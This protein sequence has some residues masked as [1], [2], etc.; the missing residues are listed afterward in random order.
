MTTTVSPYQD[1]L[2]A[3]ENLRARTSR[4]YRAALHVHSPDSYDWNRTGDRTLNDRG[5]LLAQGGENGFIEALKEH[6]DLAVITDHMRCSYASRVSNASRNHSSFLVL[7]GMEVSFQPEAAISCTRL[8][9]LV[10]LPEGST[11][12]RFSRLF[13]TLTNIPDDAS[14]T[15]NEVVRNMRLADF[16][17]RV[18]AED[19]LCIAAHVNSQQGVRHH[20]RQTGEEIIRLL[21][22][23]PNTQAEQER[24]LSNELKEYLLEA[25]FDAL[26]V[27]KAAEKRHYRW[28][29]TVR[30]RQVV[31]PVTMQLDAHCIEDLDRPERVTW[32]KMTTL[33][34]RA[35]S[36]A[37]KF[38]ETRIRFSSELPTPPSP[39]L[40]GVEILGDD[41]SLFE[42]ERIAF[43]ENLNCLIGPRGS[44]KSTIVEAL[45]YVFGYNRTL[46]E[47]DTVNKLSDRIRDMQK[48][49]LTGCLIRV[50][51]Q[52]ES[53]EK[54]IL[55]ATFDPQEDYATRVFTPE[56][57]VLP[58]ADVESSDD[59][60]LRL[61]GWSE[62]ETLGRDPSRQRDLL[63]RLIPELKAVKQKR[64][65]L[66]Q[67]LR[68]N[69]TEIEGI[70]EELKAIWARQN[71]L[72]RRYSEFKA[73]FDKLNT[74]GVKK[75]FAD[76]DLAQLKAQV[77]R[78][79]K[80]NVDALI[81]RIREL[82]VNSLREGLADLL[83]SAPQALRDWWT[84]EATPKL[85]LID[86]ETEVQ[87]H[88]SAATQILKSL[89]GLLG[90]HITAI[91][92][93]IEEIQTRI[94]TSFADDSSMQKIAD[95][96]ANAER[97]LR[98]VATLRDTY[99]KVWKRMRD[100]LGARKQI[101][102]CLVQCHDQIAGVRARHNE[103]IESTLNQYFAGH[104]KIAL[105]FN[106]GRD[107]LRFQEA[108]VRYKVAA[109]FVAQYQK[110]RVAETIG[111]HF[112]P[113]SFVRSL[114]SGDTSQFSG[115]ELDGDPATEITKADAQKA[116]DA[117]KPWALDEAAKVDALH[118]EGSRIKSLMALQEVEWDDHE[119]ILLD[120]RPVGDLSPG[121]RSSAMLPLIAL[122]ET[123]PLVIDQPEDNLDNRLIG[124]VLAVI[125]AALKENRQII[126]CTHNPNIVVSGDAEQ[127]V[128]LNAVSDRKAKV[129]KHGSIDNDDIVQA[130]ID[131]MEGGRDAFRVRQQRYGLETP[132]SATLG[133]GV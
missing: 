2:A 15:G 76:L 73:A 128:V 45:R 123:T 107:T 112:N 26:E 114:L 89:S 83:S 24:D 5:T 60:P 121:Q 109:T 57:D 43:S 86:S 44:G 133:G 92:T 9:L 10:I 90:E 33:S 27:A 113:V 84:T 19:G 65:E 117:W 119:S 61:F 95:L 6:L 103:A 50:V 17:A 88:F 28:E 54:R 23:D 11:P 131:I 58:V 16:I 40:L 74:E 22:I 39:R 62:I 49:N 31:I 120:D 115:R 72:I 53:G 12:E 82:D 122:A 78:L 38:P 118:D 102:D 67:Q 94:R 124:H 47:L 51:Y 66:R 127:V 30:N 100:T 106:A 56:G 69:R 1:L 59:Y 63:D 111:S 18:H 68:S 7:P 77:L 42:K 87:K 132:A 37:L 125:L 32:I 25:N 105:H 98:E 116:I 4:F 35:L 97:R 64:D 91:G 129:E 126:V 55:E 34:L 3:L 13:A 71:G 52:T 14:R 70:I 20:F 41:K 110:R 8:H 21:T 130:V 75:H 108:L 79:I 29:S 104:M 85:R 93:E 81:V 36:D 99:L 96:R 48:A 46:G 101:A 80:Q